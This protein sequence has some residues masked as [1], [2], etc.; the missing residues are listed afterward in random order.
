MADSRG[1][2]QLHN[3]LTKSTPA[4]VL[5][6]VILG[7]L[8]CAHRDVEKAPRDPAADTPPDPYVIGV[9]DVLRISVWQN[10]A[11]TAD[12]PV[13]PDGMISIPLIQDIKA[14]GLTPNQLRDVIAKQLSKSIKSPEVTVIVLEINS[15]NVSV[16]GRVAK[17]G[18][19]PLTEDLRVV[20][21]I[22][23]AGGF[24]EFADRNNIRIVRHRPDGS[25]V[26]FH[27][28]YDAYMAGHAPGTNF[29][30]HSGDVIYVPD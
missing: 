13:R 12:V 7:A 22:A 9:R 11:V 5:A 21:A 30:L 26:E 25:E 19:V 8:G 23:L 28:D 1:A 4:V 27:F 29:L 10:Q 2:L 3:L 16:V 15:R 24:D 20:E 17:T 14:E 6:L 18:R